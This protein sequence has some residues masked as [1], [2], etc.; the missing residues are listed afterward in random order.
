M[1][2]SRTFTY[3]GGSLHCEDVPVAV[4]ARKV[5]TPFYLYSQTALEDA[6]REFDRAFAAV[7]HLT[8][9]AVKANGNL[10][11]LSL[12]RR[13]GAGFDIVSGGELRRATA[14]GADPQRIVFSGV[15]KTVEEIDLG[16]R[17]GILQFNVE[18]AAEMHMIEGRA[19]ALGRTANVA[20]RVNP[21]VVPGTHPYISTGTRRHKFGVSVEE[22][23][24][25]CRRARMA[26]RL[27][28]T[29]ISCHIGSQITSLAPFLL[30]WKRLKDICLTLRSEGMDI[31]HLDIG[32]GLGIMYR[33]EVPPHPREFARE[34]IAAVGDLGCRLI[35]EPGRVIAGNAG[36]LVARVI[37]TKKNQGR[38][39]VVVDA[40]MSDM[41]RPSLYGAFHGI[42]AVTARRGVKSIADVVGPICETGDYLALDREMPVVKTGDCLALMSAGAYGFVLAS[43]YNSRPR[44]AEVMVRGS[45]YKLIR[46]RERYP[47]LVRGEA[48]RPL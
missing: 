25:L 27:R 45:R 26:C 21:D 9:Y 31:R 40:G 11:I 10:A 46:R 34:A 15:G 24:A 12:F 17:H 37:L 32:G 36:I 29:G 22:T 1:R 19:Q 42:Q 28:I 14:A 8:C 23:L 16:L 18:S 48:R 4:I 30:T 2:G 5:G 6:Y 35:L 20:V 41:L 39:F 7:P 33:E 47:D 38:N 43:N 44:A 13:L 3:R